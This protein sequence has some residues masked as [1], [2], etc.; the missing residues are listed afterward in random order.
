[1]RQ[2]RV[3]CHSALLVVPNGK[4]RMG[5][6]YVGFLAPSLNDLIRESF[7]DFTKKNPNMNCKE[8]LSGRGLI[9]RMRS[10]C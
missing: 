2:A 4:V 8:N 7:A 9:G 5:G 10:P 3:A 6:E 1:M